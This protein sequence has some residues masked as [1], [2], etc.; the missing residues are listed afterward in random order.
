VIKT[1]DEGNTWEVLNGPE[2]EFYRSVCFLDSLNGFIGKLETSNTSPSDTNFFYRTS[3]GGTSWSVVPD[4]P[5]PRPAGICGMYHVGDSVL[6]AVGRY[7]GP[8]GVYKTVDKG[9]TWQYIDMS[10]YVSGLVDVYFW[11]PDSGIVVGDRGILNAWDSGGVILSTFDGG[12]TWQERYSN[13]L[14]KGVCW[15]ISFP[16]KKI[17]Y[18]SKE[19]FDNNPNMYFLKTVDGGLTWEEKIFYNS[20]YNAEGIGFINDSVGWLGGGFE[21]SFA[22]EDGGDSWVKDT[23]GFGSTYSLEALN[24]FRFISDTL[25]FASGMA[26]Y[27]YSK[28]G[29]P[30]GVAEVDKNMKDQVSIYPN[31]SK[32]R[33]KVSIPMKNPLASVASIELFNGWGRSIYKTEAMIANGILTKELTLP[34]N[35]GDGIYLL[36]IIERNEAY[37]GL[38][39]INQ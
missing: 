35:T 26:I 22:T 28:Q 9:T 1:A 32:G 6:Y 31:P 12:A 11:S 3:D 13:S 23:F 20:Y 17:G 29:F 16:S 19:A 15:K 24:R 7:S 14:R 4:F 8:A 34:R 30:T 38:V 36:R 18:V 37:S 10:T 39:V 21:F 33:F 27:R 5:G 25:G 2:G